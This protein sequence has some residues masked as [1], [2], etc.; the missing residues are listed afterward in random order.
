LISS[1]ESSLDSEVI[2]AGSDG[3]N[4][5][6]KTA[7]S[8][9]AQDP[10]L[11]DVYDARADGGFPAPQAPPLACE[12]EDC[13]GPITATEDPSPASSAYQGA[14]NVIEP[15]VSKHRKK[16][17]KKHRRKHRRHRTGKAG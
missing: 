11:A 16:H 15:K 17:H 2:D 5:F 6:F 7:Q 8:L 3:R 13:Q 14:G 12:A 4:V 10:G 1:G 9:V